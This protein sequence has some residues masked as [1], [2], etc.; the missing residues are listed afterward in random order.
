MRACRFEGVA[1]L[2][3]AVVAPLLR[4]VRHRGPQRRHVR[5]AAEQLHAV[6]GGEARV[7]EGALAARRRARAEGAGGSG[8]AVGAGVAREEGV[9]VGS[10][11]GALS[12][13]AV[14]A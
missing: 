5:P 12:V 14:G 2:L 1:S 13:F 8:A 3:E 6:R 9:E 7:G 4:G 11:E 10:C